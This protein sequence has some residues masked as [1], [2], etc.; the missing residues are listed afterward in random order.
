MNETY[1]LDL[2]YLPIKSDPY[3]TKKNIDL[4]YNYEEIRLRL[5][6]HT[7]HIDKVFNEDSQSLI[8]SKGEFVFHN[9][10]QTIKVSFLDSVEELTELSSLNTEYKF[11]IIYI[12]SIQ[13][14]EQEYLIVIYK[15]LLCELFIYD[16]KLREIKR[17][18][19]FMIMVEDEFLNMKYTI[20]DYYLIGYVE[21]VV[22][23]FDLRRRIR[24]NEK[25]VDRIIEMNKIYGQNSKKLNFTN[26]FKDNF[27]DMCKEYLQGINKCDVKFGKD[28]FKQDDEEEKDY[29]FNLENYE[30]KNFTNKFA[31]KHIEDQNGDLK[32]KFKLDKPDGFTRTNTMRR[33]STTLNKKDLSLFSNFKVSASLIFSYPNNRSIYYVF[34]TDTGKVAMIDIFLN[35]ENNRNSSNSFLTPNPMILIDYH[36]S[37][38]ETLSIFENKYLIAS[39]EDGLI[40]FT[41]I[42]N[43]KLKSA[44]ESSENVIENFDYEKVKSV[45]KDTNSNYYFS[46]KKSLSNINTLF[47]FGKSERKNSNPSIKGEEKIIPP[48]LV[49]LLPLHTIKNYNKLKRILSVTQIDTMTNFQLDENFKRKT[50]ILLGFQLGDNSVQIIE[51]DKSLSN[52]TSNSKEEE[53][54]INSTSV[55]TI[56]TF[57]INSNKND[58]KAI[59]HISYQKSLIFYMNDNTIRVT[60]YATKTVDRI[61]TDVNKIYSILRV[62]EKLKLYFTDMDNI[63]VS[64]FKNLYEPSQNQGGHGSHS[65]QSSKNDIFRGDRDL[66]DS[67]SYTSNKSVNNSYSNSMNI[68]SSS[69]L[70]TMNVNQFSQSQQ[71]FPSGHLSSNSNLSSHSLNLP[72][73]PLA[74]SPTAEISLNFIKEILKN[75][76]HKKLFMEKYIHQVFSKRKSNLNITGNKFESAWIKKIELLIIDEIFE[77]INST[78]LTD[79]LKK[80]CILNLLY[81]PTIHYKIFDRYESSSQG[82]EQEIIRMG[83]QN[84]EFLNFNMEDYLLYIEK[85]QHE[86]KNKSSASLENINYYNFISLFHIWNLSIDQDINMLT[87]LKIY[88]P[89]FDFSFILK[90]SDS[91]MSIIINSEAEVD[92]DQYSD[93]S[94]SNHFKF[95]K[96]Y[97]ESDEV[98]KKIL[99]N[100]KYCSRTYLVKN[101]QGYLTNFKNYKF[102]T[103]LS[104]F[105]NLSFFGSLIAVLGFE[106]MNELCKAISSEKSL[107][108]HLAAQKYTYFTNLTILD[109]FMYE[110]IDDITLSNKDIILVDYLNI[111]T[112]KIKSSPIQSNIG[113]WGLGIGDWGLGPIPNPQSPIPNPHIN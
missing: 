101:S 52:S 103:N 56:Y 91:S 24:E 34:G 102:S 7:F 15:D 13:I 19:K 95:F 79:K 10:N 59:Y 54:K 94:M 110:H 42:S 43:Q 64:N 57:N 73:N 38:I 29:V 2:Q 11:K 28:Y 8:F 58:I 32:S 105:L 65:N 84:L 3:S 107:L 113:D 5:L 48:K 25:Y 61:I 49:N 37:R 93:Q 17:K 88:Q 50:N 80:I 6:K 46:K 66:R 55:R 63:L 106:E 78:S 96:N 26:Y 74:M 51:I 39:S 12:N 111:K 68:H 40:T 22:N 67:G 109:K 47:D 86:N 87:H 85:I 77:I 21:K 69:N 35:L 108:R 36:T 76:K 31:L 53:Q 41:D 44:L 9:L 99:K 62:E 23:I 92:E 71:N 97:L 90:G 100:D 20:I 82:I 70:N 27:F 89:I 60:N 98:E 81:N 16:K 112:N 45:I 14:E 33:I 18:S 30:N 1:F 75:E 104:H 4:E 72:S 83:G